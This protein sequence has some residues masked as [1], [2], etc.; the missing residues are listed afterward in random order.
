[1]A[2][3]TTLELAMLEEIELADTMQR[4]AN[5]VLQ[6][7]LDAS[8]FLESFIEGIGSMWSDVLK[9]LRTRAANGGG[10]E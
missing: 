2:F 10:D 7:A 9:R 5:P 3:R 8:P 4:D 1:M 6:R